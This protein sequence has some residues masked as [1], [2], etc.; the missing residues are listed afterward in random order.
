MQ[1]VPDHGALRSLLPSRY[2]VVERHQ[3]LADTVTLALAP[4]DPALA[5]GT[6]G[7]FNMLWAFGVGE[8]PISIAG[9]SQSG[10]TQHTIRDV[11]AVSH[12]ICEME[13][14]AMLGVRGPFGNGFDLPQDDGRDLLVIGGGIGLAPLRSVI[15]DATH[16]RSH[17]RRVAVLIGARSPAA[18]LYA[19]EIDDWRSAG[20]DVSVIVDSPTPEWEG[21]VGVVTSLIRRKV[22]DPD[23]TAA[24]VCGPEPMMLAAVHE[25]L[26][27]GVPPAAV[28]LSIERN[29]ECAVGSC[30]RCQ[31]GRHF[32][33]H[34]GPV[35][36]W[37]AIADA[38]AVRE[39]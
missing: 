3:D 7:Q 30:G 32:V 37:P 11:G 13:P 35:F 38:M 8:V 36:E 28:Q 25:L 27:C 34:D 31:L 4:V 26:E 12:A 10:C 29:M 33:C 9:T 23:R 22:M 14:G 16:H 18:Q 6:P 2:R 17:D 15:L 21:E 24:A 39:R 20:I 19:G 5:A 1:T